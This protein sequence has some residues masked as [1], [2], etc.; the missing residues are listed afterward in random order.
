[1]FMDIFRNARSYD[2]L[3]FG[4]KD[5]PRKAKLCIE[6]VDAGDGDLSKKGVRFVG[7]GRSEIPEGWQIRDEMGNPITPGDGHVI[8]KAH[9][10]C[11]IDVGG[12]NFELF[13]VYLVD[14]GGKRNSM[15][16][17]GGVLHY[18]S[19]AAKNG[20]LQEDPNRGFE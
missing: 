15:D 3:E 2:V 12:E 16:S 8:P 20:L 17:S 5:D 13:S 7:E 19:E 11:S 4:K 6:F 9:N 10:S 14:G 1:M 18:H